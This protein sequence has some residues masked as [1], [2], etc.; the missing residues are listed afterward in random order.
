MSP[1]NASMNELILS[2]ANDVGVIT[3]QQSK[4]EKTLESFRDILQ[5]GS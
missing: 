2:N 1:A 4:E 3:V 5:N